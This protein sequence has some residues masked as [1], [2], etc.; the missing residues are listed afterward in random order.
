MTDIH[1]SA[2]VEPGAEIGPGVQLGPHCVVH[3]GAR[4]GEGCRLHAGV[5]VYPRVRLGPRCVLHAHCVVGDVPQDGAFAADTDSGVEIG[6]GCVL[7][8]H[9]TVHRG[10]KA[11]TVTRLGRECFLMA[12][13]H[14]G[15]NAAVGDGVIMANGVLLAGYV[16]IGDRAFLS[17]NA[18]VHQFCR[19]GRLAMVS[20]LGALSQDLPPFC[21]AHSTSTNKVSGVNVVGLRRAGI[22][23]TDRGAIRRAF[24]MLYLEGRNTRDAVAAIDEVFPEGSPAREIADFVRASE[25]GVCTARRRGRA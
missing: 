11:G 16:E 15:H 25:R 2:V 20:G 8:E 3:A 19:V 17:G 7:R 9:T 10:T 13:S 5:V 1:P 23:E 21:V 6:E 22:D 14:V 4:I 12:N 24:R 18:V